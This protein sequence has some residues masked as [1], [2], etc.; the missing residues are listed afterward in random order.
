MAN[1]QTDCDVNLAPQNQIKRNQLYKSSYPEFKGITSSKI[2]AEHVYC[3][4]CGVHA[5]IAHDGNS[6]IVIQSC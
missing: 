5:S 2:D 3:T 4:I 1:R 6:N